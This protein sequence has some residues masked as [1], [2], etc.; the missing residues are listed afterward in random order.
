MMEEPAC[1]G[2]RLISPKPARGPLDNRRKS[3]Q[4]LD[5]FTAMRFSTPE[6]CTKAPQSWVASTRFGAV[7]NSMPVIRL[8]AAVALA[9]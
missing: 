1:I 7:S 9:A 8:S 4:V 3:L 5:S 6:I 2:G